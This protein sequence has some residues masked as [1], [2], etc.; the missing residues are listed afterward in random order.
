[1]ENDRS[2]KQEYMVKQHTV[3]VLLAVSV[4][5]CALICAL[6]WIDEMRN[7]MPVSVT[8]GGGI[9]LSDESTCGD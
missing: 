3:L 1:M 9:F 2:N 7:T 6:S 4:F 8:L 5:V